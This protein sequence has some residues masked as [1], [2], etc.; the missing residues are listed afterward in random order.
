MEKKIISNVI[1]ASLKEGTETPRRQGTS[2]LSRITKIYTKLHL[3]KIVPE[4]ENSLKGI[5][6]QEPPLSFLKVSN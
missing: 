2:R 4:E 5:R 3:D 1:L 6:N